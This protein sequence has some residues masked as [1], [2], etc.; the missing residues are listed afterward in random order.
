[1]SDARIYLRKANADDCDLLFEWANDET[2]RANSFNT[3]KI[4]YESHVKWFDALL[5]DKNRVQYILMDGEEPVGQVRFDIDGDTA[6]IG[7]SIKKSSRGKGYGK[8]II[9]LSISR[10]KEDY[11]FVKRIEAK[12]KPDNNQSMKCFMNNDF[13]HV[14]NQ[15]EFGIG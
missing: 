15:L 2:T 9:S 13:K 12:V 14:Y 11:P 7:Y 10:M 5:K 6:E 1:M 3:N 8:A 4:E